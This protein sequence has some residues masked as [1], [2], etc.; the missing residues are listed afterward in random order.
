MESVMYKSIEEKWNSDQNMGEGFC[1][2]PK[3]YEKGWEKRKTLQLSQR[4]FK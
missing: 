2:Y 4:G 1:N 3:R